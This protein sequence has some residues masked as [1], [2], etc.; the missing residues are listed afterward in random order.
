MKRFLFPIL[1]LW[2][3]LYGSFALVR[4]PLLDDADALHAEAAREMV[5]THDWATLHVNGIRYLEK[6]PLLYWSVAASFRIFGEH[7]WAAR[8]PLALYALALFLVIFVLGRRLFA[9]P[10]AGFY[11]ALCLLTASGIFGFTR[12]LMPDIVLCLWLSLATFFF[13]KSLGETKPSLVTALGFDICCA[14]GVLTK[15][16]VGAIFPL[17]IIVVYL[18]F[19]RKLRHLLRWHPVTGTI[20]FLIVAVPWHIIAA[21]RNP[22]I[23][24][25]GSS[26]TQGSVHG[27]AWFYFVH[28]QLGRYFNRSTPNFDSVPL[29]LFW[30]LLLAFI[31]PWC[32]FALTV[33]AR[34]HWGQVFRRE[35]LDERQRAM[36]LL[37]IWA[38]V[39][40][41]FFSFPARQEYYVLPA[42]PP[43]AL[44]AGYWLAEDERAPSSAGKI[45][46][47]ALF[48]AG[49]ITAVAL[50]VFAIHYKPLPIGTDV[51]QVL[52]QITR[53]H[54][55]FFGHFFD[56][57]RRALGAFRV[58]LSITIAAIL[59]GLTANLWFRI[60]AKARMANCFLLGT[61]TAFLIA[62]H[63]ALNTLSPALSSQI[64]ANAIKPEM[65]SD[66]VIVV[67]GRYERASSLAFYLERQVT[68]LNGRGGGLWYGSFFPDAPQIFIDNDALTQMW[69]G[70]NRVFLWTPVDQAPQLPGQPFVIGR[71]G[72]KEILSNQ[73]SS[74]GAEF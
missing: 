33:L 51:T 29:P 69:N 18:F 1:G 5:L 45:I 25:P 35:E 71:S 12:I 7:D 66:D 61:V 20:A 59:V 21:L 11:S 26:P 23:G 73:P 13:W 60:R 31:A 46:A 42:L 34:M 30:L 19:T 40:M 17:V 74:H 36:L 2:L 67:N 68:V 55:L 65:D 53:T 8:L 28:E 16:L 24:A 10:Q 47:W 43:L 4:P 38:V 49:L 14:L 52:R 63:L 64:L 44:L 56:L 72:G 6:A 57:T 15:G 3:L 22:S 41:V 58:P 27:F 62:A 70:Q 32:I 9:S 39:V 37:V 48:I 50:L 54:R